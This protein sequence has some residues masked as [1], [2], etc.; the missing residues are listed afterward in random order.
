M[1]KTQS[2]I[3]GIVAAIC[4]IL[5][6]WGVF[7]PSGRAHFNKYD[8]TIEDAD[9]NTKYKN[10]REI[11]ETLRSY[12]A[13]YE[14]DKIIYETN[15]DAEDKESAALATAAKNRANRTAATYN[16]FYLKNSYIWEDNIPDD[17]QSELEYLE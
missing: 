1:S 10:T 8:A 14:A 6:F 9:Y 2:F 4:L 16:Q 15:K 13:S 3:L 5:V 12:V 17:I 7:T 11:E